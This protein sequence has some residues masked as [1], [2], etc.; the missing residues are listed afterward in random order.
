MIPTYQQQQQDTLHY[1][2]Q[3]P[4]TLN[5]TSD[6]LSNHTLLMSDILFN[7]NIE[8]KNNTT[9]TTVTLKTL[10]SL[11]DR[12]RGRVKAKPLRF[13]HLDSI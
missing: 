7:N 6:I 12:D 11:T 2:H 1:L 3:S 5:E 13:S 10:L 8:Y 9:T 4:H